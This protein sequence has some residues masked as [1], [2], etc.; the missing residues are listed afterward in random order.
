MGFPD[1]ETTVEVDARE[2]ILIPSA[3]E[4]P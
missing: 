4:K 3:R 2:D 1:A